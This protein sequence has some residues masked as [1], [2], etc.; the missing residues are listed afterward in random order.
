MADGVAVTPGAGVVIA[1]DDCGGAGHA[2][3]V[4]LAYSADGNATP[5]TADADGLKVQVSKLPSG[6]GK[7]IQFAVINASSSGDNTIVAA[8]ASNKIKVV[9]YAFVC[10][11][12]VSAKWKSGAST[13]RSGAMAF[14]AN[15]G[16]GL[17]GTT[18]AHLLETAVNEALVL[19]LSGAVQVSGHVSYFLE[20]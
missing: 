15:G 7:T 19:N 20:A 10:S 18:D 9:S 6:G 14:D 13:D 5:I 4:K 1:T 8:Q 11:G 12:V 16:I 17:A 2:Q 3:F